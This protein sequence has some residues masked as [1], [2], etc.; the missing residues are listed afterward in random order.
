MERSK[1]ILAVPLIL[2]L[3][4]PLSPALGANV[5]VTTM[6]L[7]SRINLEAEIETRGKFQV[8]FDGGYKYR[9]KLSFQY[10]NLDLE[11]DTSPALIFDGAQATVKDVFHFLDLTYWTGFYGILGEGEHYKGHL[12]HRDPGFDY[13]GYFPVLGTGIIFG[14]GHY[15]RYRG[16]LFLY[17]RYGSSSVNSLDLTFDLS[18]DP[19][20]FSL[21][22]GA[23]DFVY[24]AGTQ[25]KYLGN[26]VELYLTVGN[27]T[28]QQSRRVE[29]DD[30]YFLLEEWFLLKNW[31]LILS[32][33]MRP[34]NHYNYLLRDYV[35]TD[36]SNDIDFNFDLNYSPETRYF[37]AGGELSIQT[38]KL[39][40]LGVSLSPYI[41]LYSS[42]VKWKLKVDFNVLSESRDLVTG[43]LNIQ[44]SF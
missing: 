22:L 20:Y 5:F 12:Y 30:F 10:Y 26:E 38:N 17:Q 8:S 35:D 28:I 27:P 40:D 19:L 4:A 36:E 23:S 44:A 11:N 16:Q 33:F 34:K 42:G 39:E 21:F 41:S 43:Y 29:F 6:D 25:L 15:E 13:D 24:R 7:T 32:V 14:A 1:F 3:C 37:S 18:S 9:A 31:N 2:L